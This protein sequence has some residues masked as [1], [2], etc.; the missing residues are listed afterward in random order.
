MSRHYVGATHFPDKQAAKSLL[1]AK[2]TEMHDPTI[3]KNHM[4][5]DL[6]LQ[7]M[8]KAAEE[9]NTPLIPSISFRFP[10]R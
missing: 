4:S 1:A 3:S 2:K 7:F 9:H 6:L 5:E 8:H 10:K